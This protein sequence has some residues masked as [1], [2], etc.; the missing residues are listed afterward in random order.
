MIPA[1]PTTPTSNS[2]TPRPAPSRTP[3]QPAATMKA[4]QKSTPED[5]RRMVLGCPR[6]FK[7]FAK[8]EA[9]DN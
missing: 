2:T 4:A 1:V 8:N 3:P 9:A 6:R 5:S 7:A